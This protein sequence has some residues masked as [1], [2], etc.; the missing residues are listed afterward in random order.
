MPWPGLGVA[1]VSS[2]N[3]GINKKRREKSRDMRYTSDEKLF[4]ANLILEHLPI[5]K[6]AWNIVVSCYNDQF[7][8][9]QR[10]KDNLQRQY[11]FFSN[12]KMPTGDPNMPDYVRIM[13]KAKYKIIDKSNMATCESEDEEEEQ[14]DNNQPAIAELAHLLI[15]RTTLAD[16]TSHTSPVT[17]IRAFTR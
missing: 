11:N 1:G 13:K 14:Y 9:R 17:C 5:G 8:D 12:K 16:M 15:G 6:E 2:N 4:L 10:N 3:D 7:P